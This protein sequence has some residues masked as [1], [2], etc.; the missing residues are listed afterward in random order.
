MIREEQCKT[1]TATHD[2]IQVQ[3]MREG[4]KTI[5]CCRLAERVRKDASKS[6]F[7]K[8]SNAWHGRR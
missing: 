4:S 2:L 3:T 8:V 6:H 1:N 7:A 5:P